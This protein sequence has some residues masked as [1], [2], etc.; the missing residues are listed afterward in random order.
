MGR[1][2][3]R[4]LIH[5]R[6]LVNLVGGTAIEGVLTRVDGPLLVLRDVRLH[7]RGTEPVSVDGAVVIDRERVDFI[8]VV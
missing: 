7:E 6:L 3:R 1:A 8:Q 2:R 5:R 4:L